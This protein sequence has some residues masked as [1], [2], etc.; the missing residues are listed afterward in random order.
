MEQPCRRPDFHTCT[1]EVTAAIIAL[2]ND[3]ASGPD[4]MTAEVLKRD[5]ELFAPLLTLL[6]N[7]SLS[8][9]LAMPPLTALKPS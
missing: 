7:A 2:Q 4:G 5:P 6:Y 3:K 1:R 9:D 8:I